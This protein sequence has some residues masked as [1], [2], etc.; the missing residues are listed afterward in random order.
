MPNP[1]VQM[2]R[3]D[4]VSPFGLCRHQHT[5]VHLSMI[6][7]MKTNQMQH[8]LHGPFKKCLDDSP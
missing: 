2:M 8:F 3:Y 5:S 4:M 6:S 7:E 1:P